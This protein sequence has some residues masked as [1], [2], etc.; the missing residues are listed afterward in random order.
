MPNEERNSGSSTL[1][2]ILGLAVAGAGGYMLYKAFGSSDQVIVTPGSGDSVGVQFK[3]QNMAPVT[4]QPEFR[5][6]LRR[7]GGVLEDL[8]Y[9]WQEG[10]WS[11]STS[12][13]SNGTSEVLTITS[14]PIP[15]DWEET[16]VIFK[17]GGSVDVRLMARIPGV[18]SEVTL[19]EMKDAIKLES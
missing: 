19:M 17:E 2:V 14:I 6:D 10:D 16:G 15:T 1:L 4:L 3:W 13:S 7:S 8:M 12:V 9:T 5:V 18:L 11:L